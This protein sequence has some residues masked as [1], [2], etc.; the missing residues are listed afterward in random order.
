[1]TDL[2]QTQLRNIAEPIRAYSLQAGVPAVAKPT[3]EAETPERKK[4]T[5]LAPLVAGMVALVVIAAAAWYCLVGSRPARAA[6]LFLVAPP[7]ANLSNDPV[8]DY[9]ADGVTEDLTTDLSRIRD[10]FV[11]ARNTAFTFKG[12]QVDAKRIGKELDV[13]YVLEGWVP[14]GQSRVRVDAR[15]SIGALDAKSAE[16]PSTSKKTELTD[17]KADIVGRIDR[18][19]VSDEENGVF[20]AYVDKFLN[21][22]RDRTDLPQL[23]DAEKTG[24]LEAVR[25]L[26]AATASVAGETRDNVLAAEGIF[27]HAA[28]PDTS[29][30]GKSGMC[31]SM[32]IEYSL[33]SVKPSLAASMIASALLDKTGWNNPRGGDTAAKV[34]VESGSIK[35]NSTNEQENLAQWKQELYHGFPR[36]SYASHILGEIILNDIGQHLRPALTFSESK[37]ND[38]VGYYGI[39]WNDKSSGQEVSMIDDKIGG[40]MTR[41]VV[42]PGGGP[43]AWQVGEE[44][45][46]LLGV[47]NAA[48]QSDEFAY[49][50]KDK[51]GIDH[52]LY[53]Y[54]KDDDVD[55]VRPEGAS[56]N[57]L[58]YVSDNQT[59][60]K[61]MLHD[62]LQNGPVIAQIGLHFIR[63]GNLT[64]VPDHFVAV[65][66][67][68]RDNVIVHDPASGRT[69]TMPIADLLNA[70]RLQGQARYHELAR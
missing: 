41:G 32:A 8:Q 25:E 40:G 3:M 15:E 48:L 4:R 19:S 38:V 37:P 64:A 5:R 34:T 7:F 27:F 53:H 28:N 58:T 1:V 35:P 46:R 52:K 6:Q 33:F 67:M 69:E 18:L 2:G 49:D 62:R 29:S 68:S 21:R 61:S 54:A 17:L 9:S 13:R 11:I 10:S 65:V 45:S 60:F 70:I 12:K 14:R 30:Q 51:M 39:T 56:N 22:N 26:L 50:G 16:A 31:A 66:A 36:R 42:D 55:R 23:S 47:Q 20:K 44:M 63:P 57:S 43:T 59:A 24:T